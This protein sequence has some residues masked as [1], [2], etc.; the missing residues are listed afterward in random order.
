M[1]VTDNT[2]FLA[3]PAI[4]GASRPPEQRKGLRLWTD[5]YSSLLALLR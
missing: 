1:L 3:L 4:A 2:A 5:D